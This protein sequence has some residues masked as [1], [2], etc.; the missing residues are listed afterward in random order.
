MVEF[1]LVG[2]LFLL[3]T[4][5]LVEISRAVFYYNV[6]SNA[7]REGGREAI[8]AYNQCSNISPGVAP[9]DGPP[10]GTSLVGVETAVKRAGGGVLGF[11]FFNA[12]RPTD[13]GTPTACAPADNRGCV[14]VFVNGGANATSCTDTAG[15]PDK[16]HGP[17]DNY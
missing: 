2:P 11:D 15:L 1:A 14:F 6:I 9:C 8:L 16:G 4:L 17:T 5:G 7:A 13:S 10:S 3:L 12:E